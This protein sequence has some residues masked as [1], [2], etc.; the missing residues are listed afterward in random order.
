[1][2]EPTPSSHHEDYSHGP[3]SNAIKQYLTEGAAQD[4][5]DTSSFE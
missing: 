3:A 1:M 4:E 5:S 2:A